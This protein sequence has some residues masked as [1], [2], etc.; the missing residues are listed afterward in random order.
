MPSIIRGRYTS[1]AVSSAL[2]WATRTMRR[3][4]ERVFVFVFLFLFFSI[5]T[6]YIY[7]TFFTLST[8]PH[9]LF[10]TKWIPE[11]T[12][13]RIVRCSVVVHGGRVQNPMNTGPSNPTPSTIP[14]SART[15]TGCQKWSLLPPAHPPHPAQ[16]AY[17]QDMIDGLHRKLGML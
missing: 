15:R 3:M 5:F 13:V 2:L 14:I 6:H 8:H 1:S 10:Q 7:I 9:S 12:Q 17:L 16:I 4:I 11:I